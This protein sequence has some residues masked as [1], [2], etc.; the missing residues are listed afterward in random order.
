MLGVHAEQFADDAHRQRQREVGARVGDP[1]GGRGGGPGEV[2]EEGVGQLLDAG[3]RPLHLTG[4]EGV[5]DE[6]AQAGVEGVRAAAGGV[7]DV[8][9]RCLRPPKRTVR[10]LRTVSARG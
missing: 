10:M 6:G 8:P 1:V 2:V 4:R 9:G 7:Y 3:A 5:A